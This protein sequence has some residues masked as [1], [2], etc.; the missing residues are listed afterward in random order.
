[1]CVC[2]CVCIKGNASGLFWS[3]M[4]GLPIAPMVLMRMHLYTATIGNAKCDTDAHVWSCSKGTR[5]RCG[6]RTQG[7][8]I[9]GASANQRQRLRRLQPQPLGR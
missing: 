7:I 5:G 8:E 4:A 3:A 9:G 6:N 2:V 1:M